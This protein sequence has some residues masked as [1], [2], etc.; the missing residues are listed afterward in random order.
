MIEN[1]NQK[2]EQHNK[3]KEIIPI[4]LFILFEE[5]QNKIFIMSPIRISNTVINIPI[6]ILD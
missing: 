3:E 6:M 5:L 1:P 2:L 4:I